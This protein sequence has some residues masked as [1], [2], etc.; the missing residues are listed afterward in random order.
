MDEEGSAYASRPQDVDDVV[1]RQLNDLLA[2]ALE[3]RQP[4][5]EGFT[6]HLALALHEY[7]A[8]TYGRLV[9]GAGPLRGALAPWQLRRAREY[10]LAHI[11]DDVG[12]DQIAS[13]CGLSVNHFVRAFRASTGTTPHRWLMAQRL[14]MAMRMMRDPG[15]TLAEVAAACGFADQS[16]L[17]RVFVVRIGIPPGQWR[18]VCCEAGGV[19]VDAAGRQPG[20]AHERVRTA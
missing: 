14:N 3:G 7:V 20:Q 4:A 11:E 18:R 9:S 17:T 16:H 19:D 13:Q 6:R 1:I 10:M 8:S 5:S 12:L 15:A 2:P